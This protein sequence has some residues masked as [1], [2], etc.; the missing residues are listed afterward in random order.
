LPN[1]KRP[2]SF[3]TFFKYLGNYCKGNSKK[4]KHIKNF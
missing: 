3:A 1:K 4:S 2:V